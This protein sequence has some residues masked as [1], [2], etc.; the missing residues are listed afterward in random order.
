MNSKK[1]D[2]KS[3]SR[4]RNIKIS[5]HHKRT[6]RKQY[7]RVKEQNTLDIQHRGKNVRLLFIV[8]DTNSLAIIRLN[9]SKQL[10]I[11][12][13]ILSISG[14]PKRNF[15]NEYKDCFGETSGLPK[16]HHIT[17]NQNISPE[18]TPPRKILIA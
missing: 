6:Q 16:V 15:L 10:N 11:I 5:N 8:A 14:S 18:V 9:S 7:T 4:T 3:A 13:K 2:Q 17:V 12:K 1:I